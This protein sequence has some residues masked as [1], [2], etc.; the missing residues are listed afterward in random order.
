[1]AVTATRQAAIIGMPIRKTMV[2][3]M[4]TGDSRHRG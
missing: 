4:L 1:M 2:S 3:Y